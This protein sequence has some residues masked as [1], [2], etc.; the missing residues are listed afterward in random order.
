MKTRLIETQ[1][2]K[3]LLYDRKVPPRDEDKK[4]SLF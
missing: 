2:E 1:R 3:K 4:S